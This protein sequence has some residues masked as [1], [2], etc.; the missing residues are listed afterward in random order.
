MFVEMRTLHG[1]TRITRHLYCTCGQLN[2]LGGH[3]HQVTA[4]ISLYHCIIVR[5]HMYVK[6]WKNKLTHVHQGIF[7]TNDLM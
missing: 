5:G 1:S 6:G 7:L 4:C 3:L 2:G